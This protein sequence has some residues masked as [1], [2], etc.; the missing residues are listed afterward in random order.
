MHAVIAV[1]ENTASCSVVKYRITAVA[2]R[3]IRH[4]PTVLSTNFANLLFM[5]EIIDGMC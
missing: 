3:K 2:A 4:A 5:L 1:A